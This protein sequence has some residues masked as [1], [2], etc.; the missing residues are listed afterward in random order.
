MF[1]LRDYQEEH[2]S[3]MAKTID[4][5][6]EDDDDDNK[7]CIFKSPTGSGKTIMMAELIK[8]LVDCRDDQKKISFIWIT[9]HK[10]H[11]QSKEKL[12]RYYEDQQIVKCSNFRDL[13][14]KQIQDKEI[15]FFNWQSIN[16]TNNIYIRANENDFNL[17][18]VI[19]NTKDVDREI[20]LIIDESHHTASSEKSK[21][22]I[23]MIDPKIT[24]N[25][26]ATPGI[27]KYDHME[28]IDF[29]KVRNEGMIKKSVRLNY[30]LSDVEDSGTTDELI[31]K[32]ALGK[33]QELKKNY[34]GVNSTVNPLMLIQIPD[35][36][37]GISD[38]KEDIVQLLDSKFGINQ[39]NGKLG[40][41]LSDKNNKINLEDIEKNTN[42]VE[43]LIFKQAITVGWDC[44]RASILVLFREWKKI[45]FS[46][47]TIGRIIRMPEIKHYDNDT[48]DHAYVYTNI[49]EVQIAEDVS[50]DYFT[51][52]ESKRS[53]DLNDDIN[54]ESIYIQR[55]HEKNRL[56]KEFYN[57]FSKVAKEYDLI[58]DISLN[59]PKLNQKLMN[60]V[61]IKDPNQPQHVRGDNITRQS[62]VM[63]LQNTFDIFAKDISYPF[64]QVHSHEIIKHAIHQFFKEN[65][66]IIDLM[67]MANIAISKE[68][69]KH[70]VRI[71]NKSKDRFQ[72]EVADKVKRKPEHISNW[73]IPKNIEYTKAYE[74]KH[75]KKCIM[76]PTYVKQETKI[77]EKFMDF[78]EEKNEV[79][80]WFKNEVSDKKYFAIEY[81]KDDVG[82][83]HAFYVDFIIRM[84]DGRIGLFDTKD[85]ITAEI[86]KPK[87]EALS[88]Y[89]KN[90]D[91][92]KL[93]GGIAIHENHEWRYNDDEE[94][95]YNESVISKWKLLDLD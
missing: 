56:N 73:N 58:K 68:N 63:Y 30:R 72:E 42:E 65:T 47:Q 28:N 50:R 84:N 2:V 77:E 46:I 51:I 70:F 83:P 49:G 4:R 36:R 76:H 45:E 75:Y 17:S 21:E 85:G 10:L 37:Q 7:I 33:R 43:V 71:I 35:A 29:L 52:Y 78:L 67:A 24:I 34:E 38:R 61:V 81:H 80:W 6:L 92:K 74:E 93:F 15:L 91:T 3:S 8:R 54:L 14:D 94:Y 23:N 59:V 41:Y 90:D 20:I 88:K 40:I 11:D 12:E 82:G 69:K 48:L 27:L 53:E 32:A 44:P 13:Q 86:A 60:S 9:V 26:S 31:I 66:E 39:D 22:I 55:K 25:V 87:A 16:Q 1:D 62:D 57:I 19:N 64:A 18:S 5:Y 89:I 79:K 95:T